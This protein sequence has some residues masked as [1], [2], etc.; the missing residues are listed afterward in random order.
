M[1]E[2]QWHVEK[3]ST[4]GAL[5]NGAPGVLNIAAFIK[6]K[7][8]VTLSTNEKLDPRVQLGTCLMSAVYSIQLQE[9][10]NYG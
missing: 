8:N 3:E 1:T 5:K 9:N 6:H 2:G 10:G 7:N 4:L